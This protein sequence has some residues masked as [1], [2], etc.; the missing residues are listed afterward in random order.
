MLVFS[1]YH[2]SSEN[3]GDTAAIVVT[4]IILMLRSRSRRRPLFK[5]LNL[6]N[7]CIVLFLLFLSQKERFSHPS[8]IV[9]DS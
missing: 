9:G 3:H 7:V 1:Y 5:G 2:I 8:K 6:D 4:K